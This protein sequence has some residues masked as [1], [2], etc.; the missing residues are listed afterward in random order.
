MRLE[1]FCC[2]GDEAEKSYRANKL[3]LFFRCPG[4]RRVKSV[5]TLILLDGLVELCSSR[6]I[7]NT[8]MYIILS[9]ALNILLKRTGARCSHRSRVHGC[10]AHICST[11]FPP[12]FLGSSSSRIWEVFARLSDH[13]LIRMFSFRFRHLCRVPGPAER[14]VNGFACDIEKVLDLLMQLIFFGCQDLLIV[15]RR[16]QRQ[17]IFLL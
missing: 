14:A 3:L 16:K 10:E 8:S 11:E 2:S 12:G 1:R 7:E 4:G 15:R 17:G 13:D 6:V 5:S 9:A